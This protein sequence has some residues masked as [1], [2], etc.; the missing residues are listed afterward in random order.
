MTQTLETQL[1]HGG[2]QGGGPSRTKDQRQEVE[3]ELKEERLDR[4]LAEQEA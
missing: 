1:P 4:Q 3:C 2:R